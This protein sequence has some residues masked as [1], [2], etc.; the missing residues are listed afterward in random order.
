[1]ESD[2][3]VEG[4]IS[5]DGQSDFDDP[6]IRK[7]TGASSTAIATPRDEPIASTS[8]NVAIDPL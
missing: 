4:N 3:E 2:S 1:M 7:N 8:A 6:G 5:S